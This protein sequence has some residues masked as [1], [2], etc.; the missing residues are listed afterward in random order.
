VILDRFDFFFLLF[1]SYFNVCLDLL[2]PEL[3][4]IELQLQLIGCLELLV[5]I[6]TEFLNLMVVTHSFVFKDSLLHFYL[7][8]FGRKLFKLGVGVILEFLD[9]NQV[10]RIVLSV[11][12][13][14]ETSPACLNVLEVASRH[15]L[16]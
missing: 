12:R 1:D 15:N 3:Q 11:L 8:E 6:L 14:I 9:I 13:L 5:K 4:L 10:L 16:H 2:Q 7:L